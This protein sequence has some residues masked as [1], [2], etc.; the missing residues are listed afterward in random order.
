MKK[1]S[2]IV[3]PLLAAVAACGGST[4]SGPATPTP[5]ATPAPAAPPNIVLILTDD[6]GWGD[7]SSYGSTTI[8]TP[9]LDRLAR[10]GVRFT[11]FYANPVCAPSRA[12]LMTGR[13]PVR[14]GIPWNPPV[15]LN[16][17]EI[18]IADALRERG[19]ATA[20]VGKWHL[21]WEARDFPTHHGFDSYYGQIA[22][23]DQDA[24]E[25]FRGDHA[26][27]DPADVVPPAELTPRY[28]QEA[29]SLIRN[30]KS[31]PFFLYLAFK[32]PHTP[33]YGAY[34]DVIHGIDTA[35]GRV[36]QALADSGADNTLVLFSSDNGPAEEGSTGPFSGRK[37]GIG[38]GSVRMP[39]IAWWPGHIPGG[40]VLDQPVANLDV[41]PTL[42]SLT[43]GVLPSGRTYD[44]VDI[45]QLLTG[46]V[47]SLSGP[48]IDGGREF[49]YWH[50]TKAAAIRSGNWKYVR[51]YSNESTPALYDLAKDPGEYQNLWNE[52]P[53]LESLWK[54]LDARLD[55]LANF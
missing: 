22:N 37:G 16:E 23:E 49:L 14:V 4:S 34:P 41:F 45:S 7:L 39:F 25:F 18:T 28:T 43:G 38:E 42:V 29:I 20:M 3:A 11:S 51:K 32:D 9:T 19:Y 50:G 2:V 33:L 40:R 15:R 30:R 13:W 55:Q 21:G 6:Q 52:R 46:E 36:I 48:G 17:G 8:Q 54:G 12:S 35:V 1:P 26:T 24:G 5:T 10:E 27:K 31:Q 44:G 53:D 47:A